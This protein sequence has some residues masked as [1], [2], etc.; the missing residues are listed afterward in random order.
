[1]PKTLTNY[2]LMLMIALAPLQV[3][4]GPVVAASSE[5]CAMHRSGKIDLPSSECPDC[6]GNTCTTGDCAPDHCA[7]SHSQFSI[8]SAHFVLSAHNPEI[9]SSIFFTDIASRSD[10]PLLRPPV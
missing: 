7:S 3:F 1:M 9:R 6:D 2:F 5:P 8:S 4:S 10:P